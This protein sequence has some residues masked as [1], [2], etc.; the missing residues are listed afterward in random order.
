MLVNTPEAQTLS[1]AN[2]VAMNVWRPGTYAG[3][4]V[5]QPASLVI[6]QTPGMSRISL[7]DPTQ[8]GSVV[9]VVLPKAPFTRVKDTSR[10][11]LVRQGKDLL[12]RADVRGLG[13]QPLAFSLHK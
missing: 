13:G 5:D 3:Y 6:R 1:Y 11:T 2:L 12:V 10:V 9:E 8:T 7:S 4:R